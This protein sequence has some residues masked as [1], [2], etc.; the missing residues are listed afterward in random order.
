MESSIYHT[1]SCLGRHCASLRAALLQKLCSSGELSKRVLGDE[2][3]TI[4]TLI[5]SC[6]PAQRGSS[7]SPRSRKRGR[8][9]RRLHPNLKRFYVSHQ[10][11]KQC[12]S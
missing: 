1:S 5:Q 8:R 4:S 9:R 2:I 11:R 3:N 6:L 10:R 7:G 12:V